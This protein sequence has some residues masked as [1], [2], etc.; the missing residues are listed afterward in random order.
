MAVAV[1]SELAHRSTPQPGAPEEI[2][3]ASPVMLANFGGTC[4]YSKHYQRFA[5]IRPYVIKQNG[6]DVLQ[7]DRLIVSFGYYKPPQD[8]QNEEHLNH[9]KHT[10]AAEIVDAANL[11]VAFLLDG[12]LPDN[13]NPGDTHTRDPLVTIIA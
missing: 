5:W 3:D 12:S 7:T 1:L 4:Y 11:I 13:V 2:I 9:M 8:W 10:Y 6:Q